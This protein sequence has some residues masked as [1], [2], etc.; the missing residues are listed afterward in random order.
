L[1]KDIDDVTEHISMLSQIERSLK[2]SPAP[3]A[4]P[5]PVLTGDEKQI[6]RAKLNAAWRSFLANRPDQSPEYRDIL[7]SDG[8]SALVPKEFAGGFLAQALKYYAPLTQYVRTKWLE[9]GQGMVVKVPFGTDTSAGLTL[10]TE[11]GSVAEVDPAF[12]SSTVGNDDL[13]AGTIKFSWNLLQDSSFDLEVLLTELAS[14]RVGRGYES[15]LTNGLDSSGNATPN[16]PGIVSV[17]QVA[18]TT[19]SLVSGLSW[20]NLVDVFDAT[21]AAYLP[22]AVWMMTS[23][24][25]NALLRLEDGTGRPYFTPAPTADG[26]DMLLGKPIVINQSLAQLGTAN[27]IPVVFGSLYDGYQMV[28]SPLRV[29]NLRERYADS[30]ESAIIPTTR[31]GSTG[32]APGALQSIKLAAS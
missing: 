27:G 31:I 24:T 2:G 12:G 25:R 29:Q 15:I 17:A 28:G 5:A 6:R 16:N 20:T 32:L 19:A 4:A 30:L 13:S 10:I 23:K 14:I 11:G 9:P 22:R 1:L 26:M 7:T 18:L 21:D 8:G 3:V